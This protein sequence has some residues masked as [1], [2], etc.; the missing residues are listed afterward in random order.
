MWDGKP[1]GGEDHL[2]EGTVTYQP[3][4]GEGSQTISMSQLL[5][6]PHVLV[7]DQR[8]AS[9]VLCPDGRVVL[10]SE[11]WEALTWVVTCAVQTSS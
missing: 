4:A 3:A 7:W 9:S 2:S 5:C 8:K 1:G 6:G 10:C 11:G